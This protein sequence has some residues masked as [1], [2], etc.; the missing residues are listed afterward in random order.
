MSKR[1][2]RGQPAGPGQCA[3]VRQVAFLVVFALFGA[4]A[5]FFFGSV[6]E[7]IRTGI[8][9]PRGQP[10]PGDMS[11]LTLFSMFI[12]ILTYACTEA[13]IRPFFGPPPVR[14]SRRQKRKRRETKTRDD[15]ILRESRKANR[16]KSSDGNQSRTRPVR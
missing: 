5:F 3:P 4:L 2:F 15:T 12:L 13:M 11:R 8:V 14:V 9:F 10:G 1:Q 7:S 6:L 16:R